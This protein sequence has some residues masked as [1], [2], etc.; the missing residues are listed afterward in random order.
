[1]KKL[2]VGGGLFAGLVICWTFLYPMHVVWKSERSTQLLW[3]ADEAY[4]LIQARTAGWSGGPIGYAWQIF[5]NFLRVP[6]TTGSNEAKLMVY[7]YTSAGLER[8]DVPGVTVSP[9]CAFDGQLIGKVNGRAS[10]RWSG[11]EFVPA[12][13]FDMDA[14]MK[15]CPPGDYDNR[16]GWSSR[17]GVQN[18]G[19]VER[20]YQLT[21]AGHALELN[22]VAPAF[23]EKRLSLRINQGANSDLWYEKTGPVF[24]S[25][26]EYRG[27]FN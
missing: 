22:A 1:M 19:Q 18:W 15:A 8:F 16:Y 24:V 6:T 20:R 11:H 7:R 21:V 9:L 25:R 12:E 23:V 10:M 26:A 27:L 3:S 14:L 5:R 13:P 4:V 17:I 2:L